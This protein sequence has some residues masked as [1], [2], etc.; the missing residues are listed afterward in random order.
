MVETHQHPG[1]RMHCYRF[2]AHASSRE[3]AAAPSASLCRKRSASRSARR[4]SNRRAHASCPRQCA[5][6]SA[7][8]LPPGGVIAPAC[9][10]GQLAQQYEYNMST[11]EG[12]GGMAS[13]SGQQALLRTAGGRGT[14]Q[15]R[16]VR[17][18]G[19]DQV[20]RTSVRNEKEGVADTRMACEGQ[21][22][23]GTP[24]LSSEWCATSDS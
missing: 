11:I 15:G 23:R 21:Q 12:C 17:F 2:H 10:F 22:E 16:S 1:H 3:E 7:A 5:A 13:A 20:G 4:E 24:P 9:A 8:G 19:S 6:P 14:F 18:C